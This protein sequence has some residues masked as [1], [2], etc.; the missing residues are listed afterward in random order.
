MDLS[1]L[2]LVNVLWAVQYPAYRVVSA[3]MGPVTASAWIFLRNARVAAV[4]VQ[5]TNSQGQPGPRPNI[6]R[7]FA[8]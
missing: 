1:L 8:I 6:E 7:T 2:V 4:L 5:R 3:A